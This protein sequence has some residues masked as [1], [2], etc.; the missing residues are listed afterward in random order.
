MY[1][2]GRL[3]KPV[4]DVIGPTE[5]I[6]AAI[7]DNRRSALQ[8]ALLQLPESFTLSDLIYKIVRISYDGDYRMAFGEDRNKVVYFLLVL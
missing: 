7:E 3:H 5:P 6:R 4:V 8:V 1:A 2:S